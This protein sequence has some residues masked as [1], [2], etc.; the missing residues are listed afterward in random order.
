MLEFK[1]R[2]KKYRQ[3]NNLTQEE[4]AEKLFVSRQAI[5]KYETGRCYPSPDVMEK[6]SELLG[7]PIDEL[8]SKEE[9]TKDILLNS[10]RLRKHR[11]NML[12]L[13]ALIIVVIAVS[14]IGIVLSVK[15]S[16]GQSSP[17][18]GSAPKNERELIGVV[19]A[20]T[21]QSPSL[22]Q[23][24]NGKLFGYC[25]LYDGEIDALVGSAYNVSALTMQVSTTNN[26]YDMTV[27][28]S[29]RIQNVY[30]YEVYYDPETEQYVFTKATDVDV[31][32]F[33]K[34]VLEYEKQGVYW[35]FSFRFESID[36][37]IEMRIKEFGSDGALLTNSTYDGNDRYTIHPDC[38]YVVVEELLK[39]TGGVSY[40]NR[41]TIFNHM[42]NKTYAYPLKILN[43]D[44]FGKDSL[45][46]EKY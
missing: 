33:D 28:I 34:A 32:N 26:I 45:V 4:F 15:N 10:D 16:H 3:D 30:L 35:N 40:Y 38:L 42:I 11:L 2:L 29:S 41:E 24:S 13:F 21:E 9:L 18:D 12:L 23:L 20:T 6:I 46:F 44:G 25:H 37:L 31:I 8:V 22:E 43:A 27:L 17:A 19:G 14:V 7:V 5:S 1:D 39:D 36:T